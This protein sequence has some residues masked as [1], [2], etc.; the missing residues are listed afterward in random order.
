MQYPIEAAKVWPQAEND[1]PK[2]REVIEYMT[3]AINAAYYAGLNDGRK[4]AQA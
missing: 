3:D 1:P 4:G 2:V